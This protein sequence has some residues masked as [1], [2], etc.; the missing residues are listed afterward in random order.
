LQNRSE[1]IGDE[2]ANVKP[3]TM[4]NYANAYAAITFNRCKTTSRPNNSTTASIEGVCNWP[5]KSKR[6]GIANCGIFKP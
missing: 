6:K 3:S 4:A 2:R 1:I 5:V